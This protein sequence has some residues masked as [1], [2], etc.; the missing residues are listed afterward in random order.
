MSVTDGFLLA[1]A[2]LI[3]VRSL[4]GLMRQRSEQLVEEVKQQLE[5]H[6][7]R[8]KLRKDRENQKPKR[9]AA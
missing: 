9:D 6:R 2:V 8:E 4:T 1:L 5:T 7:E 3:A